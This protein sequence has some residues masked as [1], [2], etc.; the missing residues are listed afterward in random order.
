MEIYMFTKDHNKDFTFDQN[1]LRLKGL[2]GN[3]FE[4]GLVQK[5][6]YLTCKELM[7]QNNTI[8]NVAN[9]SAGYPTQPNT[10]FDH[11]EEIL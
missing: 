11:L 9:P 3:I 7:A 1:S 5:T 4:P 6:V 8:Q 10:T 2:L